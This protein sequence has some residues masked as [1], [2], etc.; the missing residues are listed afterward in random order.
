MFKLEKILRYNF[1]NKSLLFLALT[2]SSY[3]NINNEK[4]EFLGDSILN[5]CITSILFNK[6]KNESEG[7]LSKFRSYLVR[8]EKL[9]NI[10]KKINLYNFLFLGN[11]EIKNSGNLKISILSSTLEALF[12]AIYIDSDFNTI[13]NIIYKLYKFDINNFNI[14]YNIKDFKT[15]L[16]EN[17]QKM[18]YFL[19]KYEIYKIYKLKNFQI[20]KI[21]CIFVEKN[22][23]T[24]GMAEK[25]KV[26]EQIAARFMLKLFKFI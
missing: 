26:A 3:S 17:L 7:F 8:R 14:K 10:S 16:Q 5:T 6:F 12:G 18:K 1:N 2:H 22:I 21:K 15:L 4:L 23:I 24:Y 20:F 9:Y 13:N 25:I 19:P 11:S